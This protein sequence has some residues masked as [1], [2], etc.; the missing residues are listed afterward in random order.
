MIILLFSLVI[1]FRKKWLS[2]IPL[3]GF[4]FMYGTSIELLYYK[5]K[6]II[7]CYLFIIGLLVYVYHYAHYC[8]YIQFRV[9]LGKMLEWL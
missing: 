6:K 9:E 8:N 5:Q 1:N 7:F 3:Y 4:K 2:T